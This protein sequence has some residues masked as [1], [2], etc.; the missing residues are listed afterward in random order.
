MTKKTE[1]KAPESPTTDLAAE[2]AELGRAMRNAL[3]AAWHSEERHQLQ[4]EIRS[5]LNQLADEME[6]AAQKIR[7][8]EPGQQVET[9]IKAAHEDIQSGKMSEEVRSAVAKALRATRD[10]IDRMGDSFT[11]VEEPKVEFEPLDMEKA[12]KDKGK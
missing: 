7:E 3:N 9:K 8:S 4:S 12:K 11:P 6:A 5:G 2:F 10:A 1:D